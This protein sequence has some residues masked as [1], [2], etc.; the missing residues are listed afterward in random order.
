MS[1]QNQR[2]ALV[3]SDDP[4]RQLILSRWVQ[5]QGM[6]PVSYPVLGAYLLDIRDRKPELFVVDLLMPVEQ[7]LALAVEVRKQTGAKTL[8]IGKSA[9]LREIRF[10]EN[11]PDMEFIAGIEALTGTA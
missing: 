7:K 8:V 5:A 11:H 3:L 4:R 1:T 6:Q 9:Y 10:T 2:H